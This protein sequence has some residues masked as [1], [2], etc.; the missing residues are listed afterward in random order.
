MQGIKLA[1]VSNQLLVN[2]SQTSTNFDN[3]LEFASLGDKNHILAVNIFEAFFPQVY[4][5]W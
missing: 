5:S 1:Q 2:V 4:Q 3:S